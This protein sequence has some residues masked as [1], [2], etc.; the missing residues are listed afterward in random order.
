V[1][2]DNT[3][4]ARATWVEGMQ[5]VATGEKSGGTFVMD[6]AS[7]FGGASNSV[8]PLEALLG[9]LAGCSGMDIISILKKKRQRVTGLHINL[10]GIKAEEYPQRLVR[11]EVEYVVRGW[12][13]APEAVARALD[14]SMGKYC[15]V[16]G[17]LNSEVVYTYRIE[18][19]PAG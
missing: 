10:R 6:G 7:E 13:I 9:S 2:E 19:E 12:D 4:G 1:A 16:R 3:S 17:S 11:I 18:A 8:R 14:L 15:S 5:F